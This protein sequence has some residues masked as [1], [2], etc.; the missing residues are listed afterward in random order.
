MFRSL[1]AFVA[2]H[3]WKIIGVW[4]VLAAGLTFAGIMRS[5]AVTSTDQTAFLPSGSESAKATTFARATFGHVEGATDV[6]LV[7]RRRDGQPLA[8][9]DRARLGP[10]VAGLTRWRPDWDAIEA[11]AE[12][13]AGGGAMLSDR[14]RETRVAS[15]ALG[16]T[17]AEGRF[18]IGSVQFVGDGTNDLV[19][20][21]FKEFRT[22]AEH[23]LRAAGYRVGATGGIASTTDAADHSRVAEMISGI[24]LPIAVLVLL[25]VFL[26]GPLGAVLSLLMVVLV[27]GAATGLVA[28]VATA[29]DFQ[30]SSSTPQLISVVL[31]GIG[32]DYLLFLAFPFRRRLREGQSPREAAA[33]TV[34]EVGRAVASAG[35]AIIAAFATLGLARFGEF[36]VLGPSIGISVAL[37]VVAALTL[38]PAMLAV[39]GRK[40]FWPGK[41]DRVRSG[42]GRA[43]RLGRA[44]ERRPARIALLCVIVLAPLV[45]LAPGVKLSYDQQAHDE[46]T[47]AGRVA[48]Q[49]EQ[50]LPKGTIDQQ[51]V[52]LSST[53][54][55]GPEQLLPFARELGRVPGVARVATPR[56]SRDRKA[57]EIG[58]ALKVD[59]TTRRGMDLVT[60]PLRDTARAE[61]PEGTT[62]LVGGSA[63]VYAD[64][65]AAVDHDL[66]LI[67]PVAALLI[68][69]VL[70]FLLRGVLAP[71]LLLAVAGIEFAATIGATVGVFQIGLGQA[72]VAFTLPL[73]VFLFVIALG[74]DYNILMADRL[75]TEIARGGSRR[76]AARRAVTAVAPSIAA[77]GI[78][79]AAS[80]ATLGAFPDDFQR[81]VGFAM[82]FGIL[83]A[84]LVVSTVLVPAVVAIFGRPTKGGD[85]GA[86]ADRTGTTTAREAI[87]A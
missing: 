29:L 82:G 3:P 10:V 85:R 19:Q 35:L 9:A 17:V 32:I 11:A 81:Q 25:L 67:F 75:R 2:R 57:A 60:G 55:L 76:V 58:V 40:L 86:E 54:P 37:T 39:G 12:K 78:V 49:L 34:E 41:V 36:R 61:A 42:D 24:G 28:L 1:G 72:G 7:L 8:T 53:R 68:G 50:G 48:K 21:A 79:L 6:T 30:L 47:R 52:F 65:A 22:H 43:A 27:S 46:G 26:R 62:V 31:V 33:G 83:L 23:E 38:M 64:I 45:A 59:A 16:P 5:E 74:T 73:I 18:A 70:V 56:L 63:A 4:L 77:A 13:S 71:L 20:R 84:S 80:F 14:V 44:I 69:L 51:Q 66:R 15:A 87:R